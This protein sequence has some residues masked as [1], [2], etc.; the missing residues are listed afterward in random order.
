MNRYRD[1]SKVKIFDLYNFLPQDIYLCE[2]GTVARFAAEDSTEPLEIFEISYNVNGR[3]HIEFG[4]DPKKPFLLWLT[5]EFF[6]GFKGSITTGCEVFHVDGNR[7]NLRPSNLALRAKTD[8]R[9]PL[10]ILK[11]RKEDPHGRAA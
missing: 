10:R 7:S 2:D 11:R 5:R 9:G 4:D 8:S 3:P 1:M 6:R